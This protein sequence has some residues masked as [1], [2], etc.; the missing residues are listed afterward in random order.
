[1]ARPMNILYSVPDQLVPGFTGGAAHATSVIKA[2]RKEG[3]KI[4]LICTESRDIISD[5]DL[6]KDPGI[7]RFE[8]KNHPDV[9]K[10]NFT[11]AFRT[12]LHAVYWLITKKIDL[13]YERGRIFG[14]WAITAGWLFRKPTIYEMNEPLGEKKGL[15][16]KLIKWHNKEVIKKAS[17]ITGMHDYFFKDIP[18]K[19]YSIKTT[20]INPEII[21][22][23][24]DPNIFTPHVKCNHIKERYGLSK[25][26]TILYSGSFAPWHACENMIEVAK[27][28]VKKDKKIKF[29]LIGNGKKWKTCKYL[30]DKHKLQ[31]NVTL[32]HKIPYSEMPAYVSAADI[33][34]ALFDRNYHEYKESGYYYSPVKLFEYM[35]AG[36][37]VVA[38]NIG[39]IKQLITKENGFLVDENDID[40][41][42]S[43]I[44]KLIKNKRLYKKISE[45]NRKLILDKY[46]WKT[47]N[48]TVL[49]ELA[50]RSTL[51]LD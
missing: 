48:K 2:L 37:P 33:C 40:E 7:I 9:Y 11:Q 16:Y 44:L 31:N 27:K 1:M 14:G 39:N 23:A 8:I 19:R 47:I 35:S 45:N 43:A 29:L 6:L 4:F 17:L 49:T 21:T 41:V 32:T 36:K 38:S 18:E 46:N 34:L 20:A 50:K 22:N 5:P 28:L 15:L 30:I 51:K 24:A 13:V 3:H 10:K 26:K 25:G 42:S 12:F